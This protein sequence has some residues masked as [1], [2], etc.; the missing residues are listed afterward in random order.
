MPPLLGDKQWQGLL[1]I[2]DILAEALQALE[3]NN[4]HPALE[5]FEVELTSIYERISGIQDQPEAWTKT[6]AW[7]SGEGW[8]RVSHRLM[9]L[10]ESH[11]NLDPE[12]LTDLQLYLNL[13]HHHL[14][15]MQRNLVLFA[16]WLNRLDEPPAPFMETPCLA[17][18]SPEL[19]TELPTLVTG[20]R[21][22]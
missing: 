14:Q 13:M 9:E 10:L 19:P 17:E 7:L 12:S 11:P 20:G 15:D 16:P 21:R 1:V 8:E 18:F 4:P 3:K 2:M 6:L 22:V 5:S